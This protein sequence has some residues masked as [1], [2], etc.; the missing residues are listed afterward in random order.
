MSPERRSLW[1]SKP[2]SARSSRSSQAA[3]GGAAEAA[4]AESASGNIFS[5]RRRSLR[6]SGFGR[7]GRP[8]RS[9][10]VGEVSSGADRGGTGRGR[11]GDSGRAER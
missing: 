8:V 10:A 5:N 6:F 3:G 7:T 1:W 2:P 9:S 11:F 4:A